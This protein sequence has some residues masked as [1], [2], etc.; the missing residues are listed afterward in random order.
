MG[1]YH[2]VYAST[3]RCPADHRQVHVAHIGLREPDGGPTVDIAV[4]SLLLSYDDTLTL[5]TSSGAGARVHGACCPS[6]GAPTL[7]AGGTL[8]VA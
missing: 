3:S 2:V 4:A 1:E 7:D 8:P 6:C 5:A